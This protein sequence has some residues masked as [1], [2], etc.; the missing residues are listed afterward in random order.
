MAVAR[1]STI[2]SVLLTSKNIL[3]VLWHED[4]RT[5]IESAF[6][7]FIP[8]VVPFINAYIYAQVINYVIHVISLPH[9][10]HS[11]GHLY[12]LIAIRIA[13]LFI[14]DLAFTAQRRN[15]VVMTTKI[16]LIFSQKIMNQL[17]TFDVELLEN[18]V[19]QD[20]FNNAKETAGWRTTNMINDI[21]YSM[22]SLL[23]LVI[24]TASLLFLNWIFALVIAVSAL[25]MFIYQARSAKQVW[26]IWAE[27]TPTRK[28]YNYLYYALQSTSSLKELKLFRLNTHFIDQITDIG[29]RFAVQNIAVLN[30]NFMFGALA[31]LANVLGYAAVEV[32]MILQT[33]ALKLS[34]GSL[35]Y[36]TTALVNFQNGVNGLF[37]SAS[38]LFD[39]AQYVQE[40]FDVLAIKPIIVS[41]PDAVK[42][43]DGV[44]P[45]IEFRNVSFSYPGSD[46]KVLDDFS[47]TIN[48]G[49][50]VAFV[51]ENG[52]GKTTLIKL[53]CRFYDV[54][55]GEILI[56]G[57]N[58]KQLDLASW[59]GQ[60]GVLFQD[61][62]KYE[63]SL[64]DNIRFGRVDKPQVMGDIVHAA[65]QSGADTVQASLSHGYDQM[66]GK[67]FEGGVDLSGGQWQKV[68]LGR[69][70]Y[71]NAPVLVLDE[72]TSTIDAKA[73]H[74][75]FRRVEQ[76][77]SDKTVLIISHRFSTVRNA[78]K[79]YVI[80]RGKIVESGSHSQLMKSAGIYAELFNLQ[81][82]AYK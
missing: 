81:A 67:L 42:L 69:G 14:Q 75:I 5:F 12:I 9:N 33:L 50:K 39:E 25:P 37:R 48:P 68:A 49:E 36:Y 74:E 64:K 60:I 46:I 65:K 51:G 40:I 72:P 54:N 31:N 23:Q 1:V 22:Q 11:Y 55:A 34:V 13:M 62:L 38:S 15:D 56:N 44:T 2:K 70:F 77:T 29:K 8:S 32:Y 27:N 47:I 57:V 43:I 18:S 4:K 78:N 52:A 6:A 21:Y 16:P 45:T 73:E 61:F 59:Y 28:R 17:A 71:R 41:P 63:Y 76:L 20:K 26:S 80:E 19:F 82:E 66:L 24:A 30:K 79:I 3:G 53:L 10:P 35:T 7:M 58:L